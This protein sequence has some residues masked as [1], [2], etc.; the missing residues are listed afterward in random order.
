M[1][2][3]E[4]PLSRA[5]E[6][7]TY[8]GINVTCKEKTDDENDDTPVEN[9]AYG[10]F[11]SKDN[12]TIDLISGYTY[13]FEATILRD[14]TD[15]Y[16]HDTYN[17]YQAPF[18]YYP[19]NDNTD[20]MDDYPSNKV[21]NFYY[22]YLN[23]GIEALGYL[24]ELSIGTARIEISDNNNV[25]RNAKYMFPRVDRFY[26][27]TV[28]V[29]PIKLAAGSGTVDIELRYKCFGLTID[30]QSIP[31]GT[32]IT[33]EDVT[34]RRSGIEA[35]LVFPQDLVLTPE[36]T[37][38]AIWQGIYSTNDLKSAESI[39]FDLKL[40]WHSGLNETKDIETSIDV[41]PG[42]NKTLKINI[43]GQATTKFTGNVNLIELSSD[44]SEDDSK[45]VDRNYN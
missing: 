10:V 13:D 35:Y 14:G 33:V 17:N 30:A 25:P 19:E 32:Y 9:Y 23:D 31:K 3:S 44:L 45:V 18:G 22:N 16:Y 39:S 21:G 2:Q 6:P 4:E 28:R 36:T 8:V 29:D 12:I 24:A 34:E 5:N 37:S 20:N 43:D 7:N 42:Y 38:S 15:K 41:K 27:T 40:T 26:G 11:T 1:D